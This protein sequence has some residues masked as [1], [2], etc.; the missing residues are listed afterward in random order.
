MDN[1][2]F[3]DAY[4]PAKIKSSITGSVAIAYILAILNLIS[5]ITGNRWAILFCVAFAVC[6]VGIHILKSRV[7]AIL[8]F[9]FYIPYGIITIIAYESRRSNYSY[10]RRRKSS[11][12]VLAIMAGILFF[13]TI[14]ATFK[15]HKIKSDYENGI[16][17]DFFNGKINPVL[18]PY[19]DS[20]S[21]PAEF[22]GAAGKTDFYGN[23]NSMGGVENTSYTMGEMPSYAQQS[24]QSEQ[25]NY[26]S[27]QQDGNS[28]PDLTAPVRETNYT[29]SWE[30]EDI[31]PRK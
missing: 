22:M 25:Y 10:R 19:E 28:M 3:W 23:T 31:D 8:L 27:A 11:P 2:R 15:Y 29:D 20:R 18:N 5:A 9:I 26:G 6:G 13:T 1:Q 16:N 12:T 24:V 17:A 4:V 14:I 7:C 30:M 21:V